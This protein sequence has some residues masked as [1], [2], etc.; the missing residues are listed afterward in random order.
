EQ[1]DRIRRPGEIG[2]PVRLDEAEADHLAV[3]AG[4]QA[5]AQVVQAALAFR[6]LREHRGDARRVRLDAIETVNSRHFLDQVLLDR[7]VEAIARRRDR[8]SP[9]AFLELKAQP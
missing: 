6:A 3:I 9:G 5:L 1:A 2:L 4:R 8:E 7:D